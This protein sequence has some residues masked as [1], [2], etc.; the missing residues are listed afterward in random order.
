MGDEKVAIMM[1]HKLL[2]YYAPKEKDRN[3][4]SLN[5]NIIFLGIINFLKDK[6]VREC[7]SIFIMVSLTGKTCKR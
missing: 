2:I 6:P 7:K 5:S 1:L 4:A 3:F